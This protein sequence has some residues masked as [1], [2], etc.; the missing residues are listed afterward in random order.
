MA[1]YAW[2]LLCFAIGLI[3]FAALI[4]PKRHPTPFLPYQLGSGRDFVPGCVLTVVLGWR[5]WL[6]ARVLPAGAN[7]P[8]NDSVTDTHDA[9]G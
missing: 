4:S 9:F 5:Q 6:A 1:G 2:L 3:P 8:W 7:R